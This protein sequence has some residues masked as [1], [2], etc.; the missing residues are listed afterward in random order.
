MEAETPEHLSELQQ[1]DAQQDAAD[2]ADGDTSKPSSPHLAATEPDDERPSSS[3]RKDRHRRE[4]RSSSRHSDKIAAED[5]AASG[6][7]PCSY[8]P[9]NFYACVV[10]LRLLSPMVQ[11]C[12]VGMLSFLC[13]PLLISCLMDTFPSMRS[14]AAHTAGALIAVHSL[15]LGVLVRQAVV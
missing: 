13:T 8:W 2:K 7:Q 4:R 9:G 14:Q 1:G 10:A 12:C 3:G 5:E 15:C 6:L 11:L